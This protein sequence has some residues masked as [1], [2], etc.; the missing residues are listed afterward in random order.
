M[1]IGSDSLR[2]QIWEKNISPKDEFHTQRLIDLTRKY[3][4]PS[5]N[6]LKEYSNEEINFNPLLLFIHSPSVFSQ[7]I[8]TL[9]KSE[10]EE[11]RI[12]KCDYGYLLWHL[13]GRKDFTP[14]L[15]N[16]YAMTIKEDGTFELTMED[17]D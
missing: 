3:G 7:E 12:K 2:K 5:S 15:K 6:R 11:N 1:S 17:C 13:G 14:M 9:M 4:F 8:A 10:K 16:G